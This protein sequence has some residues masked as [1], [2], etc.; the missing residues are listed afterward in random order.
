MMHDLISKGFDTDQ[1]GRWF[2]KY[3]FWRGNSLYC[4]YPI[5][6]RPRKYPIGIFSSGTPADR[7]RCLAL[8]EKMLAGIRTKAAEGK[9]FEKPEEKRIYDPTFRRIARRYFCNRLRTKRSGMNERY[10]L[11]HSYRH[12]GPRLAREITRDDVEAWRQ[13]MVRAGA[14]I[15]TVNNRFAYLGAVYAWANSESRQDRRLNWDPTTGMKKLP[16]GAVRHFLLTPAKFERNYSFLRDGQL[17]KEGTMAKHSTQWSSTPCP[18]FALFY[19]ALWETGRRPEEVSFYAW[20]MKQELEIDGRQVRA[21]FVPPAIAKTDEPDI[22]PVSER[23]WAEMMQLGYRSGLVFR[24]QN[25]DRWQHWERHKAKLERRFGADCG[26]IRDTRR[27]FVTRKCEVEGYDPAHVRAI[28][29]HRTNSIFERYRIGNLRNIFRVV[30][31]ASPNQ[32]QMEKS[33]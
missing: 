24:N 30:D 27:G 21:F 20:E 6:G 8:G 29:G 1:K 5:P 13:H 26:W 19:L 25:G 31:N 16:G 12:F 4:R 22:V 33:A 2:M 18:R 17:A 14:S 7:K 3:L 32:T 10:H 23:L 15:N 9:L 11:I 28:S